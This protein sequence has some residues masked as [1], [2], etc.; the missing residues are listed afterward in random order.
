MWV[1]ET[2]IPCQR[3]D[4]ATVLVLVLKAVTRF[5]FYITRTISYCFGVGV[6]TTFS[7]GL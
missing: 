5:I 1:R 7:Y 6:N 4:R 3:A 2:E